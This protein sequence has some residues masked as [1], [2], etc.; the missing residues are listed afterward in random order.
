MLFSRKKGL[1]DTS[2]YWRKTNKRETF[3]HSDS[4][5]KEKQSHYC[6]VWKNKK[7]TLKDIIFREI[8]SLVTSNVK[9]LLSRNF[10][11]KSMRVSFQNLCTV[12]CVSKT[13][14]KSL[15]IVQYVDSKQLF[16]RNKCLRP[17]FHKKYLGHHVLWYR[18]SKRF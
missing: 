4:R 8:N 7:F 12:Y 15:K 11:H 10:C 13:L 3:L 6:T 9:T 18:N 1:I 17:N 14:K 5:H 2:L 16:F